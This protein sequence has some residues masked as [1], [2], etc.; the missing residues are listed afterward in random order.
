MKGVLV[1]HRAEILNVMQNISARSFSIGNLYCQGN[2]KIP[3][4]SF[5]QYFIKVYIYNTVCKG[6]AC[7][8]L[9]IENDHI[10]VTPFSSSVSYHKS[11]IK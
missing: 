1:Y 4:C 6:L 10:H 11:M 7:K 9:N 3:Y 5:I 8:Q 2:R